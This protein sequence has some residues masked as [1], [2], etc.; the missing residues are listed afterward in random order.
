MSL[1]NYRS[2]TK[3]PAQT[4]PFG[5]KLWCALGVFAIAVLALP[6]CSDKSEPSA[7]P[8]RPIVIEPHE[9][10]GQIHAG[11]SMDQV[12]AAL[13][14][15]PRHTTKAFEYPQLGLAVVPDATGHVEWVM[16]GDVT[17]INGPF[18][19]AFNG[20][21]KEG[22]GMHST[23]ADVLKAYGQPTEDKKLYFGTESL[24][25]NNLG[26]TFTMDSGRV[27]HIAVLL[28]APQDTNA[29]MR[30]EVAPPPPAK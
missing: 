20:R 28:S 13:G 2:G 12:A 22:I 30:I 5:R 3:L 15:P 24:R 8:G 7:E 6:G 14:Q 10:V 19:K 17:G 21:T 29:T 16:C 1:K 4:S 9:A 25:Y 18:V 26:I 11:M 27:H 23:R